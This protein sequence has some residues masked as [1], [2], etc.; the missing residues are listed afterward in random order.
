[1]RTAAHSFLRA[2]C[3]LSRSS[4]S[5]LRFR[6][7]LLLAAVVLPGLALHVHAALQD[8]DSAFLGVESQ[9]ADLVRSLAHEQEQIARGVHELLTAL[10]M[11]PVVRS[12][13]APEC[14]SLIEALL[15]RHPRYTSLGIH[16]PDGSVLC[17]APNPASWPL[18]ESAH[19]T[20]LQTGE[21]AIGE[22]TSGA[23]V[24][25]PGVAFAMPI[26]GGDGEFSATL[27]L[28]LGLDWSDRLTPSPHGPAEGSLQVVDQTGMIRIR[29]PEPE[30]W[31]D[32]RLPVGTTLR[33]PRSTSFR[34]HWTH[35]VEGLERTYAFHRLPSDDS[36][37]VFVAVGLPTEPALAQANRELTRSIL[38]LSGLLLLAVG[39]GWRL[40]TRFILR[41]VHS[42]L[43]ATRR[44][45]GG[46]VSA[47]AAVEPTE[48][49]LAELAESFN[50]M[51]ESLEQRTAEMEET[52]SALQRS[53][54]RY[55]TL[56]EATSAMVWSTS[57]EGTFER[58]QPG[59]QAF[60]GQSLEE[61][62]GWGW[63][64]V[65]HPGERD[66]V[67][68]TWKVALRSRSAYQQELRIRRHDGEYREMLVRA[69]P[70]L[71][72]KG[73][74]REWIGVHTDVTER[75]RAELERAALLEREREARSE[76]EAANRSKS[77]FLAVISHELRTPLTSII[78]YAEL[79][80]TGEGETLTLRQ[81]EF[82]ERISASAWH[83]TGLVEQILEFTRLEA[84]RVSVHLTQVDVSALVVSVIEELKPPAFEKSLAMT[85]VVPRHPILIRTDQGK[86]RQILINLI[87]NA[88][89]FTKEGGVWVE[90]QEMVSQ[91]RLRVHD[92]G[93]GIAPEHI[94][95]IWNT[96]W[97][98]ESPLT[99][100]AGGT[101]LGLTI[102]RRLA[103]L[104]GGEVMV[105]SVLHE[106]STFTVLLPRQQSGK[107]G[108]ARET[109][110]VLREAPLN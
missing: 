105:S 56:I 78:S 41:P 108:E 95:K 79:M 35:P 8:R 90:L 53:D 65:V 42:L 54:E 40:G 97:Q 45:A 66:R 9:T 67:A 33:H 70:V 23:G 62:R 6:L 64:D 22:Y 28:L 16:A 43:T 85:A 96:F 25:A 106:G 80:D 11:T 49:E 38:F 63:L 86:L 84:G 61:M 14:S 107:A 3:T 32:T 15:V 103:L 10:S 7:S 71:D 31:L 48:G 100:R 47:R 83:L 87:S 26:V 37:P 20:A 52:L 12:S 21:F 73:R 81:R 13:A 109:R 91:V 89:K 27:T 88:I 82:I 101:G 69:V 74:A 2:S 36:A 24:V 34:L 99:R 92:S 94:G 29:Y 110:L 68:A 57:A 77:D 104:L 51:A 17:G 98:V 4:F 59:W 102:V 30:G 18:V 93:S 75:N 1:V 39:L 72:E 46:E 50:E 5:S 19:R 44:L 60:T 58:D 55:R 76:A